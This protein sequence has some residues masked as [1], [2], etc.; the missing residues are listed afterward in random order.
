M[1]TKT[2][3]IATLGPAS[4]KTE[5]I[6]E[7]V[8]N[9][10][11]VFRLNFSHGTLDQ[12]AK[13]LAMINEVRKD[14]NYAIAVLGDLCGPKIRVC[15][16]DPDSPRLERGDEIVIENSIKEGT[17]K[18]FGTNYPDFIIDVRQYQRILIDDGSIALRVTE[19]NETNLVCE[20]IVGGKLNSNKGIN[21]PDSKISAPAIT[22]HDYKCADWA[23]ENNLDY[24][25]LSF[26]R[27]ATEIQTLKKL[28][29][30]AGS[31]IKVIAKIEKPEAIKNLEEIVHA[32][33]AVMVA[34][35]DLG[36]E[37]DFAQVPLIQK[38]ITRLCRKT[39]KPVII[40][41][42]MLQS[43]IDNPTATR[44]EV[45]DVANAVMDF[46]DAV[47]LSGETAVGSYPVET[48]RTMDRI[49]RISETDI[50]RVSLPRPCIKAE[51]K[52]AITA[53]VARSIANIIDEIKATLVIAWTNTGQT[54]RMLSKARIDVPIIALSDDLTVS[55][56]MALDF[57]V[58]S[59]H[60]ERPA[61]I[62]DFLK[63]AND[64][65]I[66]RNMAVPG[67]QLILLPGPSMLSAD[68]TNAILFHT[69]T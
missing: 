45:S 14:T 55:R 32:T 28:I 24:M 64:M 15:K 39:A 34:R 25:A 27:T 63:F 4:A 41:T 59:I 66:E 23:I 57:G 26:V 18:K 10:V 20:V 68:A 3:I 12:H 37:M 6:K 33:D 53:A 49:V 46:T 16:I 1:K 44:A 35:G 7:L 56:Q 42:Q 31:K 29:K 47:M 22:E 30:D 43:M 65:A 69:T 38:Q 17:A 13:T 9:G 58:L 62:Q 5:V 61:S 21:L 52:L 36:V 40:A 51:P 2:K 60:A 8:E 50:D 48:V 19:K 54:P 11:D 67:D